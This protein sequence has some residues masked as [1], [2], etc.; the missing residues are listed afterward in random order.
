MERN[1]NFTDSELFEHAGK[2]EAGLEEDLADFTEFDSTLNA[3][4]K[5]ELTDKKKQV[6]MMSP[7]W[8]VKGGIVELTRSVV[9]LKSAAKVAYKKVRY[10]IKKKF[11]NNPGVLNE[12]GVKEYPRVSQTQDD[13]IL[14]FV[15]LKPVIEKYREDLVSAGAKEE[16]IDELITIAEE[17]KNTNTAQELAKDRRLETTDQRIAALNELYDIL[18]EFSNAAEVVY[19]K[20]PAKRKFYVLPYKSKPRK[21]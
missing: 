14:F 1:Y 4:K 10:F 16:L 21:E 9:T 19:K 5:Q 11:K 6:E 17:F 13:L 15:N 2:V 3:E 12:F 7:D 8:Q 18:L 20:N